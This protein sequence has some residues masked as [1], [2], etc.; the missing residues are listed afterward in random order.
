METAI[1]HA[2]SPLQRMEH[3]LELPVAFVIMPIFALANA[4][5]AVLGHFFDDLFNPVSLGIVFGLVVGKQIGILL[6]SFLAVRLRLAE[7]PAG[8]T[9]RHIW[10]VAW[11]GGIGFTMA[12]FIDGLAFGGSP[13]LDTAKTV[14]YTHLDVYKR[15]TE[16]PLETP[17]PPVDTN[18][19]P[20][21]GNASS[22][23]V[24]IGSG[25]T[26]PTPPPVQVDQWWK[27]LVDEFVSLIR[28]L[29]KL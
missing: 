13:L 24:V 2:E 26:T 25:T 10:G 21:T 9:W 5:V 18:I 15:Q 4:G 7:L 17:K 8:V 16:T 3:S 27:K 19:P 22:D 14:S 20:L 11:L 12:L 23:N 28:K 1:H 29:F 6:F